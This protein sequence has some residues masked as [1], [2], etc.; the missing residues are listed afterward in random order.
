MKKGESSS[1]LSGKLDSR[2]DCSISSF[3]LHYQLLNAQNKIIGGGSEWFFD[4]LE[5]NGTKSF[6]AKLPVSFKNAAK[7][8]YSVDFDA[9][10]LI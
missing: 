6:S 1:T 8:V 3:A 7:A 9:R 4:S 2:Y 10:E 5:A